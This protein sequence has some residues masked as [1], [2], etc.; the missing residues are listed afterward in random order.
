LAANSVLLNSIGS[1]VSL[2]NVRAILQNCSHLWRLQYGWK[3]RQI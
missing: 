1:L 2:L 3:S